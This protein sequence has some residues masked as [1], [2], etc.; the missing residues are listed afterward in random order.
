MANFSPHETKL[1]EVPQSGS[2]GVSRACLFISEAAEGGGHPVAASRARHVNVISSNVVRHLHQQI[3][4][5]T[6]NAVALQPL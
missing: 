6:I 1:E 5:T 2:A 3:P 4:L